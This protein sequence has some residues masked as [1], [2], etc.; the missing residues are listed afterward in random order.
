MFETFIVYFT[1]ALLAVGSLMVILGAV[2]L[3]KWLV[4]KMFGGN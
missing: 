1:A 4:D 3:I 2:I